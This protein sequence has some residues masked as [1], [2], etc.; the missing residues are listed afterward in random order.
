M[1]LLEAIWSG[2]SEWGRGRSFWW[3]VVGFLA[4]AAVFVLIIF[5]WRRL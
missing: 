3:G 1:E 4:T 5:L 2:L